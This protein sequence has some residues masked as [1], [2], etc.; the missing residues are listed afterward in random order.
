MSDW[1]FEAT[2]SEVLS[3]RTARV[4]YL[5]NA[6]RRKLAEKFEKARQEKG[7][8][9][10]ALAK[11]MKTSVSQVQRL[12]HKE[13]GGSLTLRTLFRA[14]EVLGLTLNIQGESK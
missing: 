9:L 1:N 6:T 12:L 2:A 10:R 8:S 3:D 4:A 11:E 5:E 7:L 14:A 13:Q